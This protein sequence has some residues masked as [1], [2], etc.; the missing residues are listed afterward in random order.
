MRNSINAQQGLTIGVDLGDKYSQVCVLD[1]RGEIV[2]EGRVATTRE[3]LER[4]FKGMAPA[5]MAIEAGTHS[6][7]VFD[8]LTSLG[9]DVVVANPRKLRAITANERKSD[10]MDALMLA[11]LRRADRQLLSPV[12]PRAEHM[13]RDLGVLRAR[14]AL[15]QA[16]TML[17]NHV[18]GVAKSSGSRLRKCSAESLHKTELPVELAGL[19]TPLLQV[20]E[21]LT[22]QVHVYDQHIAKLSKESYPQTS[23]LRQVE[24]VGPITALCFTLTIGDARRFKNARAAGAYAGLTPR[25]DQS[26]DRDP[27]LRITKCGDEMLRTLLVQCAHRILGPFGPECDLRRFGLKLAERGGKNAKR[28]A[29]VATARKLSVLLLALMRSG[30]VYE[31]LRNSPAARKE[32]A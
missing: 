21:R 22:E 14:A 19:L 4:R 1:A 10:Q 7:W 20:L 2:E 18:R 28:R 32:S 17:V 3:A 27:E 11:R 6:N 30:E 5:A 16:R 13:R 15:V 24:G 29:V 26:G 9:H 12:A 31:P 23:L 8:L 25:R